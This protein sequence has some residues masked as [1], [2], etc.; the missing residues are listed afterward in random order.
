MEKQLDAMILSL[1][2]A[3]LRW[4]IGK[5]KSIIDQ[6]KI[7]PEEYETVIKDILQTEMQRKMI[8]WELSYDALTANEISSRVELSPKQ[9]MKHLLALRREGK[10]AII[11]ERDDELEFQRLGTPLDALNL[12]SLPEE[13][14]TTAAA[15]LKLDG[16]TVESIAQETGKETAFESM[17]LEQLV[18]MGYLKIEQKGQDLYFYA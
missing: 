7:T 1:S 4:L 3:R 15:I 11:G 6:G 10:V 18:E 9:V 14:R 13:L 5:G 8:V 16:A 17:Y 2:D 12:L